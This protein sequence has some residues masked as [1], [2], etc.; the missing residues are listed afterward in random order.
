MCLDDTFAPRAMD[1]YSK[2]PLLITVRS[3]NPQGVRDAQGVRSLDS[4]LVF[5]WMKVVNGSMKS[6]RISV[7]ID[8]SSSKLQVRARAREFPGAVMALRAEFVV[9]R[10]R[11]ISFRE[12]RVPPKFNGV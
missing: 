5:G 1:A 9:A 11:A 10:R 12:G 8:E 4:P 6:A 2:Y 3:G 7:R